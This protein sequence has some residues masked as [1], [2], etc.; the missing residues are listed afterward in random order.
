MP[1]PGH[2]WTT[3]AQL[4]RW[5]AH[6]YGEAHE[7]TPET[8]EQDEHLM[9]RFMQDLNAGQLDFQAVADD[10]G[11]S[12]RH[13]RHH[14]RYLARWGVTRRALLAGGANFQLLEKLNAEERDGKL[15]G[16]VL[17]GKLPAQRRQLAQHLADQL[18]GPQAL[19]SGWLAPDPQTRRTP[20][21]YG[22][23][24]V[25]WV[26]GDHEVEFV[27]GLH[28][29]VARSLIAQYLP[30]V[31]TVADPMAGSGTIARIATHLGHAAWA[32]DRFPAQ[33]FIREINLLEEDLL[34]V[35]EGTAHPLVD[36]LFLH[37]PLPT[38]LNLVADGYEQSDE[39]YAD[40]LEK[41]LEN[42]INAVR[43]GGYLILILPLTVSPRLLV[44]IEDTLI[45]SLNAEFNSQEMG[46]T[47]RHLAVARS[48]REGW[49]LLVAQNPVMPEY[50][51]QVPQEDQ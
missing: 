46:I 17:S 35:L 1:R 7:P 45:E 2:T 43:A 11:V 36:L 30:G 41:I 31:G 20:R 42:T 19:G 51:K 47:A 18:P 9:K 6:H 14:L 50:E 22:A 5:V 25:A 21:L 26:Y 23:Q 37:P 44:Q 13:F 39:G 8:P 29:A 15:D 28:P 12:Y 40:W 10:T 38:T 32:S 3:Y 16:L 48:G 34:E 24:D 27:E 4:L 49:H 33:P